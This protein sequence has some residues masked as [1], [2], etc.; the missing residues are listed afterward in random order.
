MEPEY[1]TRAEYD[2]RHNEL[3]TAIRDLV[4]DSERKHATNQAWL[5]SLQSGQTAIEATGRT[6][7]RMVELVGGAGIIL[8][9]LNW[10]TN[11]VR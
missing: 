5:R 10:V 7:V 8:L 11:L 4:A 2:S 6:I 9:L 3:V 1:V